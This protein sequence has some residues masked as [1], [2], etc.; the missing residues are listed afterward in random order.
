[1][2]VGW[3]GAAGP[4]TALRVAE[5]VA[6][7]LASAH[8]HELLVQ[9]SRFLALAAPVASAEA[10]LGVLAEARLTTATHH[11]WAY[12]LGSQYRSSDDGEPGGTAGRPILAAIDGAGLDRIVVVVTRWYGGINLGAGGLV[13][14]YGGVTAECLRLA[15]RVPIIEAC[16]L[17]LTVGH[18][19]ESP[20][21]W[22][23][24]AHA[25]SVIERE[26]LAEGLR[27][28][29]ELPASHQSAL[30]AA[31]AERLR[32]RVQFVADLP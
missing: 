9:K 16:R 11:C 8:R 26:W 28:T 22:L 20:A 1:V 29:I 27:L 19:D 30:R 18:A 12:R 10:A 14:A 5:P 17:A 31:L 3:L 21:L 13:R 2:P 32:G 6:E 24:A 15:A 23:L 25:A 4:A 7:T